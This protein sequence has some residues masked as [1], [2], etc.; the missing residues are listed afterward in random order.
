MGQ[1][2][3]NQLAKIY[4]H[5]KGFSEGE[6]KP[7]NEGILKKLKSL[8]EIFKTTDFNTKFTPKTEALLNEQSQEKLSEFVKEMIEKIDENTPSMKNLNS[9]L[10]HFDQI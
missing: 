6:I 5:F 4:A 9:N 8:D 2:K 1:H 3:Q 10:E 7:Q